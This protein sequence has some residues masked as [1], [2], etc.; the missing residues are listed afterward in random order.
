MDESDKRTLT[1][2]Y[3]NNSEQQSD[4]YTTALTGDVK[5]LFCFNQNL[6]QVSLQ[7]TNLMTILF[8]IRCKDGGYFIMNTV[9]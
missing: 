8:N 3:I 2:C 7:H 4:V 6:S 5:R 9:Y 1:Y